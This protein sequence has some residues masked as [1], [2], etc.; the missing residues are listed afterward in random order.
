[1]RIRGDDDAGGLYKIEKVIPPE[2]VGLDAKY[3]LCDVETKATAKEGTVFAEE[4][5]E[6]AN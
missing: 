5:L 1:M 2:S 3:T 6:R 4:Q